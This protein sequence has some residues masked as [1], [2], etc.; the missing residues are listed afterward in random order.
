MLYVV[1]LVHQALLLPPSSVSPIP[2]PPSSK[3]TS[4]IYRYST[5]EAG[6]EFWFA[7]SR[8]VR[9]HQHAY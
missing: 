4:P 7:V 8:F 9:A 6:Q 1:I 2:T 3:P 5:A